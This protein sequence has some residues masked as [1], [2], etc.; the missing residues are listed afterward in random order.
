M[1]IKNTQTRYGIS[2]IFLHWLMAVLI[3]GLLALG[4]YMTNLPISL[5]KLTLYG[6]HKEYG[7]LALFLVALRLTWRLGNVLPSLSL[8]LW[9]KWAA[10][11]VHA[12][13]YVMMF[14]MPLTGWLMTS[15]SGLP[16]SFFGLFVMPDL[17]AAD[18][19]SRQ[20]LQMVHEWI[21]YLF[22]LLICLH[23]AAALKH[24]FIDKDDILRRMLP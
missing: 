6:W 15:A 20:L 1:L 16:V 8:P 17:I 11:S 2:A 13:F 3:V 23:I 14:A 24:H 7:L 10:R 18:E 5:Q 19:R 4:L 21:G 22:I 12:A 9:E